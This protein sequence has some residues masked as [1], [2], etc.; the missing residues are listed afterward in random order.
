MN[1][2]GQNYNSEHRTILNGK[3]L[4]G[5]DAKKELRKTK[6]RI[7]HSRASKIS[8]NYIGKQSFSGKDMQN[9]REPTL[10]SVIIV[11]IIMLVFFMITFIPFVGKYVFLSFIN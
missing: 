5:Y 1:L 11:F 4:Y 3:P 8:Q 6:H 7:Y 9:K 10:L 2:N